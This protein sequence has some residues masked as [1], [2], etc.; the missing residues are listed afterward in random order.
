[1]KHGLLVGRFQPFH[2]GHLHAVKFALGKVDVLWI[3]IGSAQK[4]YEKKNP[5]TAG[6]RLTMIKAVLD[7]NKINPKRWL[8]IPVNDVNVHSLWVS[9][10]DILIPRYDIVFTNDPFSSM[11]FNEHEKK[12]MKI[13][14]LK[15]KILEGTEIRLRIAS[16]KNWK[17]FVPKQVAEMVKEIDGI[18]RIKLLQFK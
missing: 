2:N 12:V 16:D 8:A 11:L 13:P 14:F 18:N 6:E 10:V 3:A 1:M 17:A 9:Q 7:V 4:S 5:F 15:R